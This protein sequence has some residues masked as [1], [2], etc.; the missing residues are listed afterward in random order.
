MNKK[1]ISYVGVGFLVVTVTMATASK[2]GWFNKS[3]SVVEN[4]VKSSSISVPIETIGEIQGGGDASQIGT[5]WPGEII[6][7][8]DVE[9]QPQREGTIVEWK[10]KIG[11][12][13]S[14][15]QVLA[16]LSSPPAT[17]ELTKTLAE[18]AQALARARTQAT[19]SA[20]FAEKNKQQLIAL[21]DALEKNNAATDNVLGD[22]NNSDKSKSVAAARAALDQ[23]RLVVEI[24]RKNAR[25]SIEQG[26]VK[27]FSKISGSLSDPLTI[28]KTSNGY[29]PLYFKTTI[30]ITGNQSRSKY[31]DALFKLLK[32]LQ[33]PNALPQESSQA[34][35]QAALGI[36]SASFA[37][38]EVTESD[39]TDLRNAATESQSSAIEALQNYE[40]AKSEVANKESELASKEAGYKLSFLGQ[41]KE[42]A[43]KKKDIEQKIA[44]LDKEI[45]LA[46]GEVNGAA[47]AY[48]T[49][50]GALTGG[51]N[52]T[53]PRAGVVS[54]ILK[55]NGDFVNPGTAVAS[56]NSG[57]NADRLVRFRIPG[58]I[59]PPKSGEILTVIRPGY[60]RDG[61]KIKLSGIGISLDG[62][63]SFLADAD[64][65]DPVDW[66]VHGSVRVLP[67][68][69]QANQI[70]VSL[71]SVWWDEDGHAN[72]WLVT[73]ENRIRP[74]EVKTGRTLGDKI[75]ILEG[76]QQGARIVSNAT[77]ELKT[78][79]QIDQL[80]GSGQKTEP[81]P[82]GDGHTHD[83]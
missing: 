14:Q 74:Q 57:N 76:L 38:G 1:I 62:N 70:L 58:S 61:K 8:G 16:R 5:S 23:S 68:K 9:V 52:I 7:S 4:E 78:G 3:K 60:E 18:Q 80:S 45:E 39:I 69:T 72:A 47:A 28:Y 44:E 46:Q 49:I 75:E 73:E 36:S 12:K 42:Y 82:A 24:K 10:V 25:A 20:N 53:A 48:T 50:A 41:G 56:I 63:G 30:G 21:R 83:E 22:G 29:F 71:S 26:V 19:A 31:S 54:I 11:Q 67:S 2:S 34:Y 55:K 15:G 35:F 77:L 65:I 51:L 64:F 32:E 33:D 43:E 81:Q 66:P 79:M 6:S 13:V 40:E 17:P 59:I 27:T 37:G